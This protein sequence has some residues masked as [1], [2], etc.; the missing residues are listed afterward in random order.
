MNG[1]DR[2][3]FYNI[4]SC[5]KLKLSNDWQWFELKSVG[6]TRDALVTLGIPRTLK[7]G[8]RKGKETFRGVETKECVV[9]QSEIDKEHADY[10][11][12]SGKCWKC[13]GRGE[14]FLSW[15]KD[16]GTKYTKCRRCDGGG[17]APAISG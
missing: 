3:D 14:V 1:E 2:V 11:V 13:C 17:H 6:D 9:T 12:E 8:P 15:K 10:E 5:K 7:S 16:E 4:I